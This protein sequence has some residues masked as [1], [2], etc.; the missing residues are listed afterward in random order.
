[1]HTRGGFYISQI[2]QLQDRIF[3]RLLKDFDLEINGPQGRILFVLW[4]EGR[5]TMGEIGLRTSLANATLTSMVDRMVRKGIVE[6]VYDETN[7][8]HVFVSLTDKARGMMEAYGEVS[9]RMN[10]IFY[11]GFSESEILAFEN[12]LARIL[13]NLRRQE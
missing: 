13:D 3:A 10:G 8:R 1:M 12:A 5:L 7:R 9:R 4:K 6:R 11:E 2:K